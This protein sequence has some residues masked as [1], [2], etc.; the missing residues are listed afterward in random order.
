MTKTAR[1][2]TTM[3]MPVGEMAQMCP[4]STFSDGV[5]RALAEIAGK[6]ASDNTVTRRDNRGKSGAFDF[7]I[8]TGNMK[9]EPH[10][11]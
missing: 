10:A 3:A 2:L 4:T 11:N 5:S 8:K 6:A 1:S 7:T 9:Q